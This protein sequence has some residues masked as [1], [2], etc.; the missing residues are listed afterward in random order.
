MR[1]KVRL[2]QYMLE[3]EHQGFAFHNKGG[4]IA[5]WLGQAQRIEQGGG[6]TGDNR[7][8]NLSLDE[9]VFPAAIF[10]E[11]QVFLQDRDSFL[12]PAGRCQ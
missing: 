7:H 12:G 8:D 9:Q 11:T 2:L 10:G 5:F 1:F 3:Q 4:K 6:L